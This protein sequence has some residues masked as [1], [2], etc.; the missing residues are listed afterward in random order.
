MCSKPQKKSIYPLGKELIY[1]KIKN[2]TK[3]HKIY[4]NK[5]FY[6]NIPLSKKT[7]TIDHIIATS[8]GGADTL[9]NMVLCCSWCNNNKGS[10]SIKDFLKKLQIGLKNCTNEFYISRYKNAI[11]V[12]LSNPIGEMSGKEVEA[13]KELEIKVERIVITA[14]DLIQNKDFHIK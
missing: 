7:S 3:L 10:H 9:N 8:K 5:C 1:S 14:F 11:N 4:S 6:C 12:C 13:V 2:R